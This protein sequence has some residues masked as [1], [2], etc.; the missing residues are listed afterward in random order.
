[1]SEQLGEQEDV[2]H[3]LVVANETLAADELADWELSAMRD[4]RNWGRPVAAVVVGGAAAGALVLVRARQRHKRRPGPLPALAQGI[5][6]VASE[7][8]EGA[9]L[10]SRGVTD[11]PDLKDDGGVD[12]EDDENR[13]GHDPLQGDLAV[14][15]PSPLQRT[16]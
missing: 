2:K 9:H 13:D 16:T 8:P 4:P 11:V 10:R 15:V 6:E 12:G 3:V 7:A 5:G 1:M 14:D